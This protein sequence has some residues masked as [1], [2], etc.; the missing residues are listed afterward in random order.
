MEIVKFGGSS[1][2][3]ETN[4]RLSADIV[5]AN[6]KHKIIVVSAPGKYKHITTKVTDDLIQFFSNG[7][8]L[9]K[10]INRFERLANKLLKTPKLIN[11]KKELYL[12]QN[13][14]L[15]NLNNY[16]LIVSRGEFLMAKLFSL[17]LDIPFIDA[18]DILIIENNGMANIQATKFRIKKTKLK[19]NKSYVIGG[20]YGQDKDGNIALFSRGGS[21]Y[22]G[23]ILAALMNASIYKNYTDTNGIQT[24]DP[25]YTYGT[26]TIPCLDFDSLDIIT[27]NGACILH[28]NVAKLL[29]DYRIPLRVDNTFDPNKIYTEIH[30]QKCKRCIGAFFSIT[31]KNNKIIIIEKK[32]KEVPTVQTINTSPETVYNDIQAIHNELI[33]GREKNAAAGNNLNL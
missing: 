5:K 31:H 3:T 23:A 24:A 11:Y 1:L 20:F 21:D 7:K 9:A 33:G 14:I 22:T 6:K 32:K 28:Q 2:A 15:N 30:S 13:L 10:I 16:N 12:T 25:R 29:K 8:N 18:K 19:R 17:Y 4:I 26:K 27:H